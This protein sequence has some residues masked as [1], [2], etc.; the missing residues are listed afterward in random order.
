MNVEQGNEDMAYMLSL[1]CRMVNK[2]L[3]FK[4]PIRPE[5]HIKMGWD[6]SRVNRFVRSELSLTVTFMNYSLSIIKSFHCLFH[7][8]LSSQFTTVSTTLPNL[9]IA[10]NNRDPFLTSNKTNIRHNY[11]GIFCIFQSIQEFF[12]QKNKGNGIIYQVLKV[13]MNEITHIPLLKK[14]HNTTLNHIVGKFSYSKK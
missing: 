10:I 9:Q 11:S 5:R 12:N 6:Q 14:K 8:F 7:S 3:F 4:V 2:V 1:I 13:P